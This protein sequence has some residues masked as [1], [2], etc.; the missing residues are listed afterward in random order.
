MLIPLAARVHNG[1]VHQTFRL[2]AHTPSRPGPAR[3][4]HVLCWRRRACARVRK[5]GRAK[6]LRVTVR[7]GRPLVRPFAYAKPST[8]VLERREGDALSQVSQENPRGTEATH[9]ADGSI[10]LPHVEQAEQAVGSDSDL[11]FLGMEGELGPS[12]ARGDEMGRGGGHGKR[13]RRGRRTRI[14]GEATCGRGRGGAGCEREDGR[15]AVPHSCPLTE[16]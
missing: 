14:E 13:E 7:Q 2:N 1:L 4:D 9:Q 15:V 5:R 16:S 12:S 6:R 3:R 8:R 10:S 11:R